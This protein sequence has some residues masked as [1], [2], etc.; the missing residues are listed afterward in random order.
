MT[1]E[2]KDYLKRKAYNEKSITTFERA[3]KQYEKW[4][5]QEQLE[6]EEIRYQDLLQFMK[7][8]Q[9]RDITQRTIQNYLGVVKHYYDYLMEENK[10][11]QNPT[12]G[13]EVKGVKR[14]LLYHIL[15]PQEL[16][17]LYNNYQ[18]DTLNGK[19]NKILLGLLVYQGL[20]V[21]DLARL[22][23]AHIQLR[24]G[25]INVPGSRRTNERMLKLEAHQ[26]LDI[27]DYMLNVRPQI[28][29]A[30]KLATEQLFIG[31]EGGTRVSSFVEK[32]LPRLR[33]LNKNVL[34][35]KQIRASVITKWLKI[36]NLREV[37]YR[38][39]H[40]YVSSTESYK[41]NDLEGLQ[42]EVNMYHPLG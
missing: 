3:F 19:R 41:Q 25:Q 21:E 17:A 38:A 13:I 35:A 1:S 26:V 29:E 30:S 10:I 39:G 37:Q 27:Y 4:L 9:K 8:C 5:S 7:H 33:K 42:E 6:S 36:Y 20:K 34:N 12:S 31:V 18:Q 14:K 23:T 32:M 16:N 28:I 15:E 2:F 11:D 24:E 22:E 40:R